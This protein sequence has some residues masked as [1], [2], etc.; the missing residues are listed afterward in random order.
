[1]QGIIANLKRHI[2]LTG[3][4]EAAY[5]A[6]TRTR[7]IF[8]KHLLLQE[9]DVGD[10]QWYV[11][12]GCLYG[13][14]LNEKGEEHII[15]FAVE[16]QWIADMHS[17]L[18]GMPSRLNIQAAEDSI[19]VEIR[20]PG[21]EGLYRAIPQLER[22]GRVHMENAFVAM[23]DRLL[24]AISKTAEERYLDFVRQSPELDRRLPQYMIASYLGITPEFLSKIRK[25]ASFLK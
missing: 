9:G 13:Y 17:F 19:V 10:C 14:E 22:F 4:E 18:T 5:L 1:M 25:K 2:G 16:D 24:A 21:L 11:Q 23:Q 20:R 15:K 3:E 12:R 6:M 7:S 8:R